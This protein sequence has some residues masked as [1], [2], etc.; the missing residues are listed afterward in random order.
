M[1]YILESLLELRCYSQQLVIPAPRFA[2]IKIIVAA[3]GTVYL[4]IRQL[5]EVIDIQLSPHLW[6]H[7][8]ILRNQSNSA[9]SKCVQICI[10]CD[11]IIKF[12]N[13]YIERLSILKAIFII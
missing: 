11:K 2:G 6:H 13:S 12:T 8:C 9:F 3:N 5:T 4:R 7:Y 10:Y 1:M